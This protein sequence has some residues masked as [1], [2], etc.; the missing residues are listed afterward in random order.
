MS[1][2]KYWSSSKIYWIILTIT[3]A[4]ISNINKKPKPPHLLEKGNH[5]WEQPLA[6]H[7]AI[8]APTHNQL[9]TTKYLKRSQ[10]NIFDST[11]QASQDTNQAT[12]I[13]NQSSNSN[14]PQRKGKK[15]KRFYVLIW[16]LYRHKQSYFIL[17]KRVI[18]EWSFQDL[19]L[20]TKKIIENSE[21][22]K[23]GEDNIVK[24]E[25]E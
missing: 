20:F 3:K 23:Q 18:C 7:R 21:R 2:T 15:K 24:L 10:P 17:S 16:K 14:N 13:I 4:I 1:Q 8:E 19:L 6:A 11:N 22:R 9:I 12:K 5:M 25:D